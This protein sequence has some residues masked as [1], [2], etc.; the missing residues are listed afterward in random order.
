MSDIP[1][2]S[3]AMLSVIGELENQFKDDPN[4]GI[5]ASIVQSRSMQALVKVS[6]YIY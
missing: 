4:I 3:T 1:E 6:I 2:K 5:L